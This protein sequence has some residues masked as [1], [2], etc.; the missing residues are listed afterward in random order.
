MRQRAARGKDRGSSGG[1]AAPFESVFQA[2]EDVARSDRVRGHTGEF[3]SPVKAMRQRA[4]SVSQDSCWIT[5][6]TP[7]PRDRTVLV[8]AALL[9]RFSR[10]SR[11]PKAGRVPTESGGT[12][13]SSTPP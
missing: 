8:E 12:G 2:P 13:G 5:C 4:A 9:A 3:N 10:S 6:P 1:F 11:R 7:R